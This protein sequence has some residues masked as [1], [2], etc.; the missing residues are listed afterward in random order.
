M[1]QSALQFLVKGSAR[2]K[3]VFCRLAIRWYHFYDHLYMSGEPEVRGVLTELCD[4]P[5]SC[6]SP[7]SAGSSGSRSFGHTL[8][9]VPGFYWQ[10]P[11]CRPSRLRSPNNMLIG[12]AANHRHVEVSPTFSNASFRSHAL[13]GGCHDRRHDP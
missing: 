2:P 6:S 3:Y 13:H 9:V 1:L 11:R 4:Q 8:C 5:M 7:Y 10:L 12:V